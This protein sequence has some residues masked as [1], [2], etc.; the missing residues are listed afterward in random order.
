MTLSADDID[1]GG[2]I[3]R[4]S[5]FAD[6]Y[7]KYRP[8]PPAILA[9]VLMRW[10]QLSRLRLVVDLG[11]GT[12]ISTRY[13]AEHAEHVV[14]IEPTAD[15]RAQA[16]AQTT[17]ANVTYRD[18]L[19][20]QTGLAAHTVQIVACSQALHWME[21][22]GTFKEAARILVPGGVFAA[23][24]Y[25]WPP[26]TGNWETEQAYEGCMRRVCDLEKDYRVRTPIMQWDKSGHLARMRESGHFRYIREI[27]LHHEDTGNAE[28][29]IGLLMSQGAVM[30]LLKGGFREEQLGL[31]DFRAIVERTLG[32][33]LRPWVWCAR[34]RA[35]IV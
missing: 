33:E 25:D 30:T 8:Q 32:G 35:A 21:P 17:A 11:S 2:N 34:V 19:S 5:G 15:M 7:D 14:G 20:H 23:C 28:R 18:G 10:A 12:G 4:F 16:E 13:W 3:E 22:H 27:T 24:D 29:L 26:V 1:F 9:D 6:I 31:P